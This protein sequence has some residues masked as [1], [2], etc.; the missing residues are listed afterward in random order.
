MTHV[1]ELYGR[2]RSRKEVPVYTSQI[3]YA[4]KHHKHQR[5]VL[6][7]NELYKR[8]LTT[9]QDYGRWLLEK[10]ETDVWTYQ[11]RHANVNSEMTR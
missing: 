8:P 3:K 5:N 1:E 11:K 6:G 7:P 4:E 10:K 2:R 9:T